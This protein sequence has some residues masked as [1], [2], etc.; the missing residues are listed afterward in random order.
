MARCYTRLCSHAIRSPTNSGSCSPLPS[1]FI[2]NSRTRG[3]RTALALMS[4]SVRDV[5][6]D[7]K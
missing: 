3:E 5:V 4:N 6:S 1:K 2:L 7:R